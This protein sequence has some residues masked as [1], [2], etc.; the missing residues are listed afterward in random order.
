[1]TVTDGGGSIEN[2]DTVIPPDSPKQN[3]VVTENTVRNN[4]TQKL[5]GN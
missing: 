2:T 1:M 5:K 3:S 4:P